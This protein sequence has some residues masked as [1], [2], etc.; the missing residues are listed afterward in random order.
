MELTRAEHLAAR[1][2]EARDEAGFSNAELARRAGVPRR[3]IVRITNAHNKTRVNQ[4][5]LEALAAAT[6]KPISFFSSDPTSR[7]AAAADTLV[8]ALVDELRDR[9]RDSLTDLEETL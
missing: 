6:G 7:V 3:T 2:C 4:E 5:T 1:I 9:I 8:A